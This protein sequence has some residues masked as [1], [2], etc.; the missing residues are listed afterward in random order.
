MAYRWLGVL[1]FSV[2]IVA[3]GAE[4]PGDSRC[5]SGGCAGAGGAGGA[6][7]VTGTGGSAGTGGTAIECV[8]S[9]LCISCPREGYCATNADCSDGSICVESGCD[10]L[11][12]AP[13][14]QCL[15]AG[16]GACDTN[17]PC[18]TGRKCLDV[19]GEGERCVRTAPGC[20][21]SFDCPLGFACENASCVDRRIPCSLDEHCP[22]NHLC[23]SSQ[24]S[25]FCRRIQIDCLFDF[26]CEGLA[27]SCEDIDGDGNKECA[28][29]RNPNAPSLDTCL[30]AQCTDASAPVCEA[31]SFGSTS[32]CGQYGL[33]LGDGDCAA[34]FHCAALWQ[35]GRKECVPDGGSCSSYVDCQVRQVCAS[36]REGGAPSCQTGYQP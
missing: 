8:T 28:G 11:E 29:V 2:C 1:L 30:N 31:S 22:K 20:D 24:N 34:G 21:T 32:D 25:R 23:G 3:C 27:Q 7:G 6:G 36:P 16:G 9:L 26:D 18:P 19:P 13:I 35:D 12:G 5:L 10:D 4:D 33:C 14:K 17:T 15:F